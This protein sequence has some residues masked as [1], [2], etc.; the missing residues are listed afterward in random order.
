MTAATSLRG[1]E[2]L[3]RTLEALGARH[4]FG[5]PGTQSTPFYEALRRSSLRAIVPT[6]E[7][8]AAFM[9][10]A[11]HRT[12]NELAV[13]STIPGPGLA[14]TLAAL[15]EAR[16]DS[17]AIL[18]VVNARA[19]TARPGYG[20]QAIDQH[21]L[22]APV[23]KAVVSVASAAS[24][25]EA[26]RLARS[27]ALSGEPGPVAL[28]LSN[29][30]AAP[31]IRLVGNSHQDAAP[32]TAAAID[33]AWQTMAAA[34][35]PLFIIGQGSLQA[36]SDIQLMA[37]RIAAPVLTTPSA[38]GIVPET[39]PLAMG[40][41]VLR[42]TLAEANRLIEKADAILVLG[43][44]LAHNGSAGAGLLLPAARCIRVDTSAEALAATYPAAHALPMSVRAFLDRAPPIAR[45]AW[46]PD[47]LAAA[48]QAMRTPDS[49]NEPRI[50]G[51]AS[52]AFFARMRAVMPVDTRLVTDTGLHQVMARRHLDF[53]MPGGLLMPSD[54]QS[55]GFGL[56]AAIAARLAD[57]SRPVVALLGDGGLRMT[58]F[59]IETAVRARVTL[60]V[61]VFNDGSLNQI[62]QQQLSEFGA[63]SG[64]DLGPLDLSAFALTVG[65]NYALADT[66]DALA[67][68]MT[69]SLAAERVDLI[70]VPVGDTTAIRTS[71][72]IARARTTARAAVGDGLKARLKTLL[73]HP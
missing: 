65:A 6:H 41:D 30:A 45:S 20:P 62:R 52:A 43:A 47:E 31:P 61:V 10:A 73:R 34:R 49:R 53:T 35:R 50:A 16:L 69:A 64:T 56:P 1:A 27:I 66:P 48:R 19:P 3:C 2:I 28:E 11:C 51:A 46:S 32:P 68:A 9:A 24:I 13:L 39:G 4:V 72:L 26:T 59:E 33:A 25:E 21:A 29:D 63:A 7:L 54:F 71:T 17:A 8:A 23:T 55:M 38:R 15:A 5:V 42:G 18:Y 70:E 60:T 57:P 36:A 12:T 44:K 58:G 22:L 40:F 14:Y 67:A 37:E